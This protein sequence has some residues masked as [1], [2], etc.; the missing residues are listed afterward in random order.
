MFYVDIS[1]L[2]Y[3]IYV[4]CYRRIFIVFL[5][6]C[7]IRYFLW[8]RSTFLFSGGDLRV[9]AMSGK[10]EVADFELWFCLLLG[11]YWFYPEG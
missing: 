3:I 11:I 1:Y 5:F 10:A 8:G 9:V 7:S 6:I 4:Y 2:V